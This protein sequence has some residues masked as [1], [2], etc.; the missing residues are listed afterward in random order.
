MRVGVCLGTLVVMLSLAS[1]RYIAGS[2]DRVFLVPRGYLGP[3][4][5]L[6]GDDR[7]VRDLARDGSGRRVFD[8][9]RD[10]VLRLREQGPDILVGPVGYFWKD[11]GRVVGDIPRGREIPKTA[12]Q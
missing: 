11:A 2:T 9:P 1:C 6:Y 3:V 5:V 12:I 4:V 8:V 7:G 10:G